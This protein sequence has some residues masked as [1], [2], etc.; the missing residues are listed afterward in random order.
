MY[1]LAM[2]G[3][4]A[5]LSLREGQRPTR[6]PRAGPRGLFNPNAQQGPDGLLRIARYD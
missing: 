3:K 2:T 4:Q 1:A 6:Q 5:I